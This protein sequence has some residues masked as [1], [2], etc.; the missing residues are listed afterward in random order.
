MSP[1]IFPPL[2]SRSYSTK[3]R[4]KKSCSSKGVD[5]V[6][7]ARISIR[8]EYTLELQSWTKEFSTFTYRFR[9]RSGRLVDADRPRPLTTPEVGP[10]ATNR[11]NTFILPA[12]PW[13]IRIVAIPSRSAVLLAE[14]VYI[15]GFCNA[16]GAN[17]TV[18]NLARSDGIGESKGCGNSEEGGDEREL[19]YG[20]WWIGVLKEEVV[21]RI[22]LDGWSRFAAEDSFWLSLSLVRRSWKPWQDSGFYIPLSPTL[23]PCTTI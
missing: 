10:G 2:P 4:K 19:H 23:T 22:G 15:R 16:S 13:V 12:A 21:A 5:V 8:L 9:T 14:N 6:L 20:F 3:K 17:T 11:S 18:R 7:T 1:C